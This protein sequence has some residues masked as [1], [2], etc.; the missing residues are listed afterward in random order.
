MRLL[1]KRYFITPEA[2]FG[3]PVTEEA[4]ERFFN[5]VSCANTDQGC[6]R[7]EELGKVTL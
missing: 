7:P 6:E 4:V 3:T 2:C 1:V 5:R